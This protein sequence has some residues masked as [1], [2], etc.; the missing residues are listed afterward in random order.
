MRS[1]RTLRIASPAGA[2]K[3]GFKVAISKNDRYLFATA[4]GTNTVYCYTLVN[5]DLQTMNTQK[6]L[7]VLDQKQTIHLDL[8]QVAYT[9]F[10]LLTKTTSSISHIWITP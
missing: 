10:M 9:A 5:V 6:Q 8:R 4:P 1:N 7:L 2:D 3:F